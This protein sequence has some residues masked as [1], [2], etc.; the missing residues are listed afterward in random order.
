MTMEEDRKL[1]TKKWLRR[2]MKEWGEPILIAVILA[3]FIRTF[4][5]QAFKIPSGSMRPTLQEGDKIM[6]NKLLFGPR[7][8][9]TKYRLPSLREPERGDIIVFIYPVDGRDFIKRL[10]ALKGEVIEIAN[11]N[12]LINPV[13]NR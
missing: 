5:I 11:G 4:F 7:I 12:I 10:V 6:V 1:K 9:F 8:P 2:M 13:A 3:L